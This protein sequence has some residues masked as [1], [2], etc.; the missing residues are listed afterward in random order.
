VKDKINKNIDAV[1]NSVNICNS[2]RVV[3]HDATICPLI[4][5][6]YFRHS[7]QTTFYYA[8]PPDNSMHSVETMLR[9][10]YGLYFC[11]WTE[12]QNW[13][14]AAQDICLCFVRTVCLQHQGRRGIVSSYLRSHRPEGRNVYYLPP[15]ESQIL[16]VKESV[17]LMN[18]SRIGCW[19]VCSQFVLGSLFQLIYV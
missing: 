14:Q 2:A 11:R 18:H 10:G 4:C 8:S 5:V 16:P 12:A 1:S 19:I 13:S 7:R 9:V 17:C 6:F 3:S 15:W